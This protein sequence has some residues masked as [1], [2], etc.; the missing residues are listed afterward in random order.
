MGSYNLRG[1]PVGAGEILT[2]GVDGHVLTR[3]LIVIAAG[4]EDTIPTISGS[5]K[6]LLVVIDAIGDDEGE[7]GRLEDRAK[8]GD[9]SH[10]RG[11]HK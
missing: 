11:H 8:R 4:K 10:S 1:F 9:D 6:C 7:R 3:G 5:G 2:I